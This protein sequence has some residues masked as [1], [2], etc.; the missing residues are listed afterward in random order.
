MTVFVLQNSFLSTPVPSNQQNCSDIYVSEKNIVFQHFEEISG[1]FLFVREDFWPCQLLTADPWASYLTS[2]NFSIGG[3]VIK[4]LP[5]DA[6][7]AGDVC[8]VP[9]S[10]RSPGV[11]NGNPLWYSCLENPMDY[12]PPDSSV[13]V[14]FQARIL[15]QVAI[16]YPRGS[17]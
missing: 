8:L 6:G 11:G 17:S 15:E 7:D 2:L 16:S 14:I 12:S 4:N 10:G 1:F 13:H 9:G 3:A 5:A